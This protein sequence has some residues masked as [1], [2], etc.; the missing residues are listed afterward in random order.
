MNIMRYIYTH[1][2]TIHESDL[3]QID[4]LTQI[5][6]NSANVEYLVQRILN[7]AHTWFFRLNMI[8]IINL[9]C[10]IYANAICPKIILMVSRFR[11]YFLWCWYFVVVFFFAFLLALAWPPPHIWLNILHPV[12]DVQINST[13]LSWFVVGHL[14]F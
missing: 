14:V 4:R 13:I 8:I 5:N 12:F 3:V 9:Q 2:Q 10:T 1:T 7:L 6:A 11:I